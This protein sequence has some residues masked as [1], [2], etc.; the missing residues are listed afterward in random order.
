[1]TGLYEIGQAPKDNRTFTTS[2]IA[3]AS[4]YSKEGVRGLL[5]KFR[6][7]CKIRPTQTSREAVWDYT[8]YKAV[9]D[10][11]KEK[12]EIRKSKEI[13]Q[14]TKE[15]VQTLEELKKTHPLV[16]DVRFFRLSYFPE[17]IPECFK[18]LD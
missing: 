15:Y 1:M 9:M 6:I 16:R 11:K 3:L 8:A 13:K 12:D 10:W 7:K 5:N 18:E 14:P 2:E 17:T 4:G